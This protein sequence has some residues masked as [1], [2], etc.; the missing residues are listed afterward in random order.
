MNVG[1]KWIE[2]F[3]LPRQQRQASSVALIANS[4]IMDVRRNE[5]SRTMLKI[6]FA[7]ALAA[8]IA[9]ASA[10]TP[11]AQPASVR[12]KALLDDD[13]AAVFRRSPW[14]ATVRGVPGYDHLLPDLSFATLEKERA[15]ERDALEQLK[16]IDAGSLHGQDRVSYELRSCPCSDPASIAF[17]CSS[18]SRWR[19]A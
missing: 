8:G 12:L 6:L 4:G 7:A 15:R 2:R 10:Q 5:R 17:S 18:A 9:T 14:Q 16:A 19:R 1:L 3:L 13:L 11:A